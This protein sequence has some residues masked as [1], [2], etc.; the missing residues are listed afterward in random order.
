[1]DF[2]NQAA[3]QIAELFRSMTVAARITTGL[4]V[5]ILA[6]SLF[7]LFQHTANSGTSYLFNGS[8]LSPREIAAMEAAFAKAG[9]NE[10][11]VTGNRV[12]VP[13]ANRHAYLAALDA[14]Q[15]TAAKLRDEIQRIRQFGLGVPV[16]K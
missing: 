5:G 10:W 3:S 11:E 14:E 15:A 13:R 7:F 9:L 12:R 8:V 1:M 6:V 2:I 16:G 4:L